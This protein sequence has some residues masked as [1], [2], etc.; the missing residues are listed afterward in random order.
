MAVTTRSLALGLAGSDVAELQTQLAQLGLSVPATEQKASTFGQGTHDVVAQFQTAHGLPATGIVDA[1]TA[2]AVSEAVAEASYTVNGAVSSPTS[3]GVGGLSVQLVD[4]NVG[5]DVPLAVTTTQADGSYTVTAVIAVPALQQRHK[6]R[7][8]LQ[9]RVSAGT[10][11]LAAS[12]VAY[13]AAATVTLDVA[14][15]PDASLPSEYET[16]TTS[17]AGLYTGKLG[18][19][20]ETDQQQDITFLANKSKWDA[21]LVATAAL[22]DQFSQITVPAPPAAPGS[23]APP[24]VSLKPEFYYALF[25]AG[26]PANADTLF[27][28]GATAV[29]EVWQQSVAQGVI[30][31]A[32][33]SGIADAVKS[34]QALSAAHAL[35]AP[36][37]VGPSTLQ[38]MLQAT[39]PGATQQLQFAQLCAQYREDRATFWT[40]VTASFGTAT[41]K[42]LQ[43][44]G[45]LYYLTL[46]NV[47]LVSA[48]AT[49]EKQAPLAS[50]LDL[51]LRGYH[52]PAK[53]TPLIG[54]SIPSQIPGATADAQRAN[55][56]NLLATQVRIAFPTAVVADLMQRGTFPPA[57]RTTKADDVAA[58]LTANAASFDIGTEPVEAYI[59]RA[60]LAGA[61]APVVAEI[62]RLQRVRQITPDDQSMAILIQHQLDSAYAITRYDLA[63]FTRAFHDKLGGADI[64]AQIHARARQ[65]YGAVLNVATSYLIA[66][67]S[68]ATGGTS[69]LIIPFSAPLPNPPY[70]VV[71]YPTLENLFGSLDYCNCEECRSILSPAA[72]L[73]DLLNSTDIPV[74]STGYQNP[75]TALL[76]RRPDLQYLPLTCA[77]TNTALPYID[78]VNETLE[79]FVANSLSLAGYQGFDTGSAVTSAELMANPQNVNQAAYTALRGQFFP[80]PLP[81][82]RPLALLRLH[83]QKIGVALPELMAALRPSDAIERGTAPYG[84]R[85]ILLEQLAISREEY[86]LFTD[87]TLKLQGLY[88]YPSLSDSAVLTTLQTT[89][90]R[91]LSRR[92]GVSYDDLLAI[93]ATRFINPNA[94]LIPKVERLNTPFAALQA[95]KNGVGDPSIVAS[96]KAALPAGLDARPYGGTTPTDYDAIVRW[97]TDGTNY[98]RIM[99]IITISNPTNSADQCSATALELRY[100]NPDNTANALTATD[101]VKL[102]RFIRLWRKLGLGIPQ[103]DAILSALYPAADLPTGTNDAANLPLL[104]AGFVLLLP[105]IGFLMQ[106]MKALGLTPA[107][108]LAQLLAC[109]APIDTTGSGSLYARMFLSPTLLQPDP[110]F[111]DDGYGNFLDSSAE[112]LLNHQSTLCAA[113]GITGAEFDLITGSAVPGSL[114]FGPT[115]ALT[116]ANISAV[117]RVGS[118]AHALG[119]S[120]REFMLLRYCT[121]LDPFAFLDPGSPPPAEPPV[122]RFIRLVRALAAAGI[123]PVQALYLMWN[124]DISGNSAPSTEAVTSLALDLRAAFAAVEAQFTL[125]DDPDGSIAKQMMGLVYDSAA[126]D[127]FFG[128]LNNTFITSVACAAGKPILAQPIA[129]ASSGRLSYDDLRKQLSFAGVL[130]PATQAA[131][132]Q[133]ITNNGSDPAL[134]DALARLGTRNK[135][136]VDLFFATYQELLPLFSTYTAATG[137]VQDRRKVLLAG[138][139]P[140][141]TRRRK[142]QQALTS[143]TGAAGADPSFAIA[144]L[145]DASIMHAAAD[146]TAAAA[147]DLT[148]IE[149][150]GLTARFF[151]TNNIAANPDQTVDCAPSLS[152]GAGTANP[153]PSGSGG[154]PIAATWSGYLDVPQD[155]FYNIAVTADA[156][157][158][159]TLRIAG[160]A[161][162]MAASGNVWNNQAPISLTAGSLTPIALTATSVKT[163]MTV[164]WESQGLGS[165][166]ISPQYLYAGMLIDRLRSTYVGFLK[167]TALSLTAREIVWLGTATS[168]A[169]N[170]DDSRDKLA[171]GNA[172]F[173]PSSMSNIK[174]GSKLV[175]DS[176]AAQEAVTVTAVTGTTFRAVTTQAHDGTGVPFPIV[177]QAFPAL[178]QGWLSFLSASTATPTTSAS[179]RD[180][181]S[182]LVAF[183]RIKLAVSPRDERLLA[184]MQNPALTLADGSSALLTLTGWS[185]DSL[186]ALLQQFF[187]GTQLAGLSNVENFRRV[188]D[189]YAFV[190]ACRIT[191]SVLITGTTNAPSA[192]VVAALQSALRAL[193]A[194]TDWLTAVRP[195]NDAIRIQQRD[196]LVA[197]ILQQLGDG[198]GQAPRTAT[199]TADVPAGSTV[200]ALANTGSIVVGMSAR[201]ANI[202]TGATVAAVGGSTVTISAATLADVPSGSSLTFVQDTSAINTADK[203]FEYFLIDPQTQPPVDTSRIRLALSSV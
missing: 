69:P 35:T 25:R 34:F 43:F 2:T 201:G 158:T 145:Q 57:S 22:A 179:L 84:W 151:L 12:S 42:Q 59:A 202:A 37:P 150:G 136:A 4:K 17:L 86:R 169:V 121:G 20:Q 143:I 62:K 139:L 103:T 126:T 146:S 99:G 16:L 128:L 172:T 138:L 45:Q 178:G 114:G 23:V 77:N 188:Y 44:N 177:S 144:L 55:Y 90:L 129:D 175:V 91:D 27:Q 181:L 109:W 61:P 24:P 133:A 65:I 18:A 113:F 63:G 31:N 9:V 111:A 49:A 184:V 190:N 98:A 131:I 94:N 53:W 74:P 123:R 166:P 195:I 203:L 82:D 73:V 117:F 149:A 80:P 72:Y 141:L 58:F 120:V 165:Q 161:V 7:P 38:A 60:K 48:L 87:G 78:L 89:S 6:T 30:P 147:S 102:M 180:V 67:R 171:A 155:G 110:A 108:G 191:A 189:A 100:A 192:A 112:P 122:I 152:Y 183:S 125:V 11:F 92:I 46:N 51:A 156:G 137:T 157:A 76:Q 107:A 162:A 198:N 200:L 13:D 15:P 28:A 182:A 14:L 95:L 186:A 173:T 176:G 154:S 54:N 130:D 19:L 81:F 64:A 187:G 197:C 40:Q 8:D 127:F 194:D 1:A 159:I 70:P 47:P 3:A 5:A 68:P 118:L 32:L 124:Q 134:H 168:F 56:A 26:L 52:D 106:V 153:L 88:G 116:L 199:T 104:D 115:T 163:T 71:A 119:I 41:A 39:L 148:A 185:R 135:Q 50:A 105:R 93:V 36:P 140:D 101:F 167:A 196:A 66:R 160:T 33:A 21:R 10:T 85:D 164:S 142:Q 96:F 193:Y 132:D 170:T 79:Y 83:L 75:L 29:Q 97:V 174:V